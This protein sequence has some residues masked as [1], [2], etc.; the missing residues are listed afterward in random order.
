MNIFITKKE[1]GGIKVSDLPVEYSKEI[2]E[3]KK[4]NSLVNVLTNS[5]DN[6]FLVFIPLYLLLTNKNIGGASVKNLSD[7]FGVSVKNISDSISKFMDSITFDKIV[8]L[9]DPKKIHKNMSIIKKVGPYLP[10]TYIQPLNKVI[11]TFEKVNRAMSLMD[12]ISSS[13]PFDPII[14]AATASNRE[15]FNKILTAVKDELP[16]SRSKDLKPM[17]EVITNIDKIKGA[18]NVITSLIDPSKKTTDSGSLED[19]IDLILPLLGKKNIDKSKI[20]ELVGMVE[21]LKVLNED[22]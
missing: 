16:D 9:M 13:K 15:R 21:M 1:K 17:I 2:S 18:T 3:Q 22:D 10:Q 20:K 11:L 4:P 7:S 19:L 14:P 8:K 6:K 5:L 12:F